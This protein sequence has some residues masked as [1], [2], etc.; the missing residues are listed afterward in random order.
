MNGKI[1]LGAMVFAGTL[2]LLCNANAFQADVTSGDWPEVNHDKLRTRYSPLALINTSNAK[3]LKKACEYK[4]PDT[5]RLKMTG[6]RLRACS[7]DN[8]V[9]NK[10]EQNL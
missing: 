7:I 1:A 6:T 9:P 4:F 3:N 2:A 10:E 5:V 8:K